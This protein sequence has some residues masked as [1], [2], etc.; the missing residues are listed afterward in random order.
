[1]CPTLCT[2][3][4]IV[5]L[6]PLLLISHFITLS[7]SQKFDFLDVCNADDKQVLLRIKNYLGNPS[8]LS[9]WDL[10]NDCGGPW[11]GWHGVHCD[12]QG[13][14]S[15]LLFF[16]NQDIHT[17]PPYLD[18]LPYLGGLSFVYMNNLSGPIPHYIGKLTNLS[19]FMI[20]M[21]NVGGPI[22]G[23]LGRLTNL[24]NL[25]LSSSKFSGPIPNFL[26]RL[27]GLTNLDLSDNRLTGPIPPSLSHLTNL[28]FLTIHTNNLSGPI[29]DFI[30]HR[31]VNLT[32]LILHT[33]QFSGLIPA[34]LGLLPKLDFL[35]LLN[36]QFSGPVPKSLGGGHIIV[37]RLGNN[38]LTGDPTFLIDKSNG[39]V[40]E[41][42]ISN[43]LFKFDLTN[44][45]LAPRLYAFNMSHNMIYG[46][47]PKLF[48]KLRDV[49]GT[50]TDIK[51]NE[52][53]GPIPNGRRLKG[54]NPD[55]FAHNKCLCGGP[56]PACK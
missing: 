13:R 54:V 40:I 41:V 36:N 29:P 51:Y 23:F 48:Y 9:S 45:D 31:L 7:N 35:S 2:H 10:A 32:T 24:G 39:G 53:C 11:E 8:S 43:N 27:K 5:L 16:G 1:M 46:R 14:I 15:S 34:S 28:G 17:I 33:N 44:V 18:Q 21:T 20:A 3:H 26:R 47:L 42:D 37:I 38:K 4:L 52:L 56:L 6:L 55:F 30:G 19:S 12:G 49:L 50:Y 25:E 22:P